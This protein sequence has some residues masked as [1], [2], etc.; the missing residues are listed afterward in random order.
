[1]YDRFNTFKD[2]PFTILARFNILFPSAG[3]DDVS[4]VINDVTEGAPMTTKTGP[5]LTSYVMMSST[6]R[7][8]R[9]AE[10][11]LRQLESQFPVFSLSKHV[12]DVQ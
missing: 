9:P 8:S 2:L 1:V 5:L 7:R 6:R 10:A 4:D 11:G 3:F 12:R